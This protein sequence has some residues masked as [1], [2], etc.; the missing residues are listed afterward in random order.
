MAKNK[1]SRR[2]DA[3]TVEVTANRLPLVSVIIPMYNSAKFIPQTLISLLYQTMKD[4]EVVVV[5]DCSTDNSVEVVES[6]ANHFGGR[7]HVIKLHENSGTPN[8]P[9]NVGIQYAHGKY[10][11]FLDSDDLFTPTSLAEQ[12][13][14]AEKF[15][16]DVVHMDATINLWGNQPKSDDD[17]AMTD[18]DALLNKSNPII[19]RPPTAQNLKEPTFDPQSLEERLKLWLQF[20]WRWVT[21]SSFCRRDFLIANQIFFPY[22]SGGGD[23]LFNF[24]VICNAKKILRVPNVTYIIRP[25]TGS[26]SREKDNLDVPKYLHKWI[27]TFITGMNEYDK[28]MSRIDFFKARPDYRYAIK[29]FFLR[30]SLRM[31]PLIYSRVPVFH[32]NE[33]VKREFQSDDAALAS[34]LFDMFNIQQ[35]QLLQLQYELNR[36]K[37]SK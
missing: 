17:P 22:M 31:M 34:Y 9:R 13:T 15:Q 32:L 33:L 8:L 37:S 3:S 4:F 36:L 21:Y 23:M 12:V 24:N 2:E 6:F 19:W 10:I 29:D 28:I 26:V 35:L 11:A 16:A 7:L 5:D 30:Q 1:K 18:M 20:G 14:L 25:R 27:S